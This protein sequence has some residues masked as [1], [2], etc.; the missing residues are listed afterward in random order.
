MRLK[1]TVGL[2]KKVGL[3]EYGSLGA[4]C[5]V[6]FE[7]QQMLVLQDLDAFRQQVRDAFD[8]CR[9]AV[10]EELARHS[11]P[12]VTRPNHAPP[13]PSNGAGR[14]RF[15][16]NNNHASRIPSGASDKQLAYTRRL[17]SQIPEVGFN[18]LDDLVRN[19]FA[20]PLAS[21][22]AAEASQLI[23][24][25]KAVKSGQTQLHDLFAGTRP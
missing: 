20:Q 9:Q 15:S 10:E 19:L 2:C 6:E 5:H 7:L 23:D 3:P 17:A 22:T 12:P 18:E 21:L 4:S 8:A 16:D 1:T 14:P 24:T 13:S 25:L 11:R